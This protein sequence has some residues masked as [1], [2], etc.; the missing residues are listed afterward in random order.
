MTLEEEKFIETCFGWITPDGKIVPCYSWKHKEALKNRM[1]RDK[2]KLGEDFRKWTEKE[3]EEI[4]NTRKSCFAMEKREGSCNAEWHSYEIATDDYN[5]KI[6]DW[7]YSNGFLRVGRTG[8]TICVEGTEK[9]IQSGYS[10]A[11]ELAD[12][13]GCLLGVELELKIEKQNVHY[14]WSN[15]VLKS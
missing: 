6:I 4:E 11:K 8:N 12:F 2:T 15:Y 1:G 10:I 3:E 14:D 9:G 13:T 5:Y 7:A